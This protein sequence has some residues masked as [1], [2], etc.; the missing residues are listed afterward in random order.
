MIGRRLERLREQ[1]GPLEIDA[2][3]VSSDDNRRYMSGFTGSAGTLIISREKTILATDF[4]Y[5]EQSAMEAPLFEILKIEGEFSK[6][7][8]EV[9]GRA[10]AAAFGFEAAHVSYDSYGTLKAAADHTGL[11]LL[12]TTDVV[13]QLRIVKDEGELVEIQRA[14]DLADGAI[15]AVAAAL[16]PGMTELEAAW[17]I[18][19]F[20]HENGG[21][22]VSFP[23]IVGAGKHGAIPHWQ[24]TETPFEQGDPVVFDLGARVNGYCSDLTRTLFV[25]EPDEKF[26][27][28]YQ[29]V[30]EAQLEAEQGVR[31]GMT[32]EAVDE[33][34]RQVIEQAGYGEFFGHGLGHGVGLE[35]HEAP[36]VGKNSS[37]VIGNG[38]VFT[39]EPGIYLPDW[40]GV[41]I[42]DMAVLEG[43]RARVLSR[44][45]KLDFGGH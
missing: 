8:A 24:P 20:I 23:T 13:E 10:D 11:R 35:I 7:L 39:I 9:A 17:R 14:V 40:G 5:I 3:I 4:R 32:G 45:E 34:A 28:I 27:N 44:A 38:M 16:K 31:P 25:G 19:T 26:K 6:H 37:N 30:L 41:R 15:A 43:D 12:A 2:F 33:I 1:L 29:I 36:R 21:Q 22:G 18:E 42:E